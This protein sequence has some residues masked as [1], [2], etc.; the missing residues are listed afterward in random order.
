MRKI[1]WENIGDDKEVLEYLRSLP[2]YHNT[3]VR[4]AFRRALFFLSLVYCRIFKKV[5]PL[6]VVLVTN[7]SCNLN[8]VYC[9]GSYG[10]RGK[11]KDY[12]TKELLKIIDELKDLGT[13]LITLHGGESLL[14]KDI[15]EI[16]NYAKHKG[17]YISFNTNGYLIPKRIDE[18]RSID[19]IAISMD[20]K[21]ES[22]DRNRGE[23]CYEKC[24][25]AIDIISEHG[26]PL[27]VS[28]T[29]T[30]DN[31]N[32]ME[33]LAELGK[34]KNC[35]IQY[36]LLYN[37]G[38]LD[39]KNAAL[40]MS[41]EEMKDTIKKIKQLRDSGYPIYW[42]DHVLSTVIEWPADEKSFLTED[43]LLLKNN[44]IGKKNNLIT[45]YH[46]TLKYQID[47]DGRVVT[48]WA[49][50]DPNAPN[51]KNVGVAEAIKKCH[52]NNTCRYCTFLANNEHNDL[53][54]LSFQGIWNILRIQIV[55]TFKIKKKEN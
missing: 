29:L 19:V 16:I 14:R 6:F 13:R 42:S 51:I 44:D 4:S 22:N 55:D 15:G 32:D 24:M 35:R 23:G 9:Y 11:Y 33:F 52:E 49:Q 8:C 18:L 45:C 10:E 5:K 3:A 53:M 47:A 41:P 28:A 46:G 20:G 38:T 2:R 48:C 50:N 54:D 1:D 7:N 30:K 43:D 17:F 21:K 27:V 31:M 25:T 12:T 39:S 26:M 40:V 37:S 34:T 36:H